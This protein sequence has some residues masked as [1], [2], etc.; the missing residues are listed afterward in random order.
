MSAI[1]PKLYTDPVMGLTTATCT[2]KCEHCLDKVVGADCLIW[3]KWRI[4]RLEKAINETIQGDMK[5]LLSVIDMLGSFTS[6]KKNL[7]PSMYCTLSFEG[8]SSIAGEIKKIRRHL[9]ELE[10]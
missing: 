9:E 4:V 8:D 3:Y 1:E 5:Y 7:D 2:V 6:L 10:C